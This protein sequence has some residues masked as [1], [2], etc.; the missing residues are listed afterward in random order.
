MA[1]PTTNVPAP[2]LSSSGFSA[3][4]DSAILAGVIAD[5]QAAF[6]GAL[7]LSIG[8]ASSLTTPQGQLASS[9]AAAISDADAQFLQVSSQ[10][11]PQ[12]AQGLMQDGIAAVFGITRI[13]ATATT[14][15]GLCLGLPG[16]VIPSGIPV[17]Q[18]AAGNLYTTSGGTIPGGGSMTLTFACQVTGPVVFTG[19]LAIYQTIPGWDGINN[20]TLLG[21]GL[22]VESQQ[23]LETRRKLS[24]G[25]N[26][27]GNLSAI[28]AAVLASGA[29]LTPAQPPADV[30]AVENYTNAAQTIG[31]MNVPG[32]SLYVCTQGGDA[33]AI[34]QALWAKKDVGCGYAASA[35]FT[36]SISG[37][38]LNVTA[39]SSGILVVGQEIAGT[40]IPTGV[41]VAS[42][43]TGAGGVGTYNLSSAASGTIPSEPMNSATVAY[44]PDTTYASPQPTYRVVYTVAV[45]IPVNILV[46]LAAGSS[47]PSNALVLLSDPVTGLITAFNGTDGGTPARIGG[48]VYG[49]RFYS[50]I[51][52]I[53][54]GVPI[55]SVTVGTGIPNQNFQ[56]LNANQYPI[57]GNITLG[58][59]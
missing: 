13:P 30:Y 12:Y 35:Y 42:L 51:A 17:A 36:A 15:S 50:T 19:P 3:P 58:F 8:N 24:L 33:S 32:N 39:I 14:V 29:T 59:A 46:T 9:V 6:G 40:G 5:M 21:V 22:A 28:R 25:I 18:D 26:S 7:N 37:T 2:S 45:Q 23:A 27:S 11:D 1:N 34:A 55:V 57:I 47:P 56:L 4:A 41:T 54:P 49:S 44:V 38:V 53:L 20:S 31:G 52:Q 48:A 16:T 43:G 10:V